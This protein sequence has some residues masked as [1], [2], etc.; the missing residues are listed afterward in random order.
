[1]RIKNVAIVLIIAFLSIYGTTN[2]ARSQ[3]DKQSKYHE[4]LQI[5]RGTIRSVAWHPRDD[6]V[7]VGGGLGIWLYKTDF[8]D[9]TLLDQHTGEVTN[10]DWNS[11]G[12]LLA[13]SSTDG[14]IRVWDYMT[15]ESV[16]T[17]DDPTEQSPDFIMWSP[18]GKQLLAKYVGNAVDFVHIWD[19]ET[20]EI[21]Q[22]FTPEGSVV[23]ISSVSWNADGTQI[24]TVSSGKVQIWDATNGQVL[25]V[26]EIDGA[27]LASWSPNNEW[28]AVSAFQSGLHVWNSLTNESRLVLDSECPIGSF[29]WDSASTK[30]INVDFCGSIYESDVQVYRSSLVSAIEVSLKNY[31]IFSWSPDQLRLIVASASHSEIWNV[32]TG[33]PIAF[34]EEHLPPV[35]E[36]VWNPDESEIAAVFLGEPDIKIW[37]FPDGNSQTAI[38][39]DL[40]GVQNLTWSPDGNFLANT[41]DGTEVIDI[42][43]ALENSKTHQ[44]RLTYPSTIYSISWNSDSRLLAS[45][46]YGGSIL[47]WNVVNGALADA[48]NPEGSNVEFLSW[49]PNGTWLGTATWDGKIEIW[50]TITHELFKSLETDGE[51]VIFPTTFI[52]WHPDGKHLAG[53]S[54]H[55]NNGILTYFPWIWNIELDEVSAFS[56]ISYEDRIAAMAWSPDSK[57]LAVAGGLPYRVDILD[58]ETGQLYT[59]ITSFRESVNSVAWNSN[60]GL[61]ATGSLDGAVRIWEIE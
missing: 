10:V 20:G 34:L 31:R 38:S 26:I 4:V 57:F 1:M 58:G 50:D 30:I 43:D 40:D 23:R 12:T 8:T 18:T 46:G 55:S 41:Y 24:L 49:S 51:P 15:L 13:S 7:A 48:V 27:Q 22:T 39:T 14:T 5:G 37:G 19:I 32:N 33:E 36:V 45:V 59:S 42:W 21:L 53:I 28:V 29:R 17:L 47:I 25:N 6:L 2:S 52:T 54:R 56:E 9:F 35:T 16:L 11:D 3:I 60:N 61:L 44:A